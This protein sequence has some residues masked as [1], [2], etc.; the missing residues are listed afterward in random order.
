MPF[1]MPAKNTTLRGLGILGMVALWA[2][3]RV[4]AFVVDV[5][6]GVRT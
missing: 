5:Y 4:V 6:K 3:W 2:G 1:H